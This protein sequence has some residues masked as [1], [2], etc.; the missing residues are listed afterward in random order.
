MITAPTSKS[1]SSRRRAGVNGDRGCAAHVITTGAMINAPSVSPT[2]HTSHT[3]HKLDHGTRPPTA[4]WITPFVALINELPMH[5][6]QTNAR[7]SLRCSSERSNLATR[8][9]FAATKH[10]IVLPAA[11]APAVIKCSLAVAF[12]TNAPA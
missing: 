8:S 12:A 11:I 2:H 10:A 7:T 6:K 5:P 1:A 4:S 3:D 9:A